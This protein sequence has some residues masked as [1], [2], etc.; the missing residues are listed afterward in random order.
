MAKEVKVEETSN[1]A[2]TSLAKYSCKANQR[3]AAVVQHQPK[4]EGRC[5]SPKVFTIDCANGR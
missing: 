3:P 2:G 5:D 1:P 4:F